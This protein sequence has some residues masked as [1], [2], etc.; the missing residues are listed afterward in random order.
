MEIKKIGV[1]GA[2]AMGGGI[3]QVAAQAGY[4]VVL[5]DIN[6]VFVKEALGRINTFL[7]RSIEKGKI[8]ARQ[9]EEVNWV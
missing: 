6:L 2:G 9:K 1:L 5:S 7:N 8:K 4:E 3:A